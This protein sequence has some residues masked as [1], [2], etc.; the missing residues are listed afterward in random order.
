[1][2]AMIKTC[3]FVLLSLALAGVCV[4]AAGA[5]NT[6]PAV[7][8]NQ[9]MPRGE[10][11]LGYTYLRSNAPPGGC[12]CFNMNGGNATFAWT[13]KP[14]HFAVVGDVTVAHAGAISSGA[15]S[16][17]LSTY[18]AGGRYVPH[19]AHSALQPFG[20]ALIGLAYASGSL[21]KASSSGSGS[22]AEAFAA[23][24]GGGVDLHASHRFY[25]RLVE[26]DYLV[27]TFNNGST[28]HQNMLRISSGVVFRFGER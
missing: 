8:E 15:Y 18:T 25:I 1:M 10:L 11:A 22:G 7:P 19:L 28:N 14:R 3:F 20:Q 5:Q 16:L 23:N 2:R 6:A 13:I 4:R 17:T 27:T 12:G 26:A 24:V 21:A 9:Q